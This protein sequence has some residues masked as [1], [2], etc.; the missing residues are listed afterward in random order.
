MKKLFLLSMIIMLL[1][2]AATNQKKHTVIKGDTLWDIAGFYYEDPFLWPVIYKANQDSISDPHWIYPDEV[3]VIPNVP[4]E[5]V[6]EMPEEEGIVAKKATIEKLPPQ[7]KS[8]YVSTKDIGIFSVVKKKE[9]VFTQQS[10]FL[11]GF[12]TREELGMGKITKKYSTSEEPDVKVVIGEKV[13]INRGTDDGLS[14]GDFYT[15]FNWG[16]TV[17]D[18]GRIVRIKGILKIIKAGTEVSTA[19]L[20]ETYEPIEEGDLFMEYTSPSPLSGKVQPTTVDVEGEIIARKGEEGVIKPF[21]VV[22]IIP[23]EGE[24]HRGDLFL[25]YRERKPEQAEEAAP[26]LP[27]GKIRIVNVKEETASGYVTT[28]MGNMNIKVGDKIRLAG[29]VEQ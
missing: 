15:V 1:F 25:L 14:V 21:S 12:I 23:G 17:G 26:I 6:A 16:K 2:V 27:L 22:Y 29:R 18:Y 24:V 3:F 8:A 9:Y 10:A 28:L 13:D 4:E 11:A 20:I 19:R 5:K 7:S